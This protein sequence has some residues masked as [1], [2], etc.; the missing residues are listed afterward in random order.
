MYYVDKESNTYGGP[1]G[2][3]QK[4]KLKTKKQIQNEKNKFKTRKQIL[5]T[6]KLIGKT[7]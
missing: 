7:N 2:S 3:K 4:N 5:K 1:E 6:K